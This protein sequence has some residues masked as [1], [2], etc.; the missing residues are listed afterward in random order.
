ML[1]DDKAR[2]TFAKL[3]LEFSPVALKYTYAPPRDI[4][5]YEGTGAFCQLVNAASKADEPFYIDKDND[6]C[7]GKVA[8][9]MV[10]DD[11]FGASGVVGP[12]IDMYATEAPNSRLHDLAPILTPGAHNCVIMAPIAKCTFDPDILMIVAPT[13]KAEIILRA[14]SWVSGDPWESK[15]TPVSSCIWMYAYPY[16][17][18]KVN[19]CI[20]G[21][22]HGLRRRNLYPAGMHL[23]S[24]PFPKLPETI[25]ALEN[26]K[27][28]ALYFRQDTEE[29][30]AELAAAQARWAAGGVSLGD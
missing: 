15:S 24:I 8:L 18:G 19:F 21:M 16:V 20:T 5:R 14:T 26:M 29:G 4:T 11:G 23:I 27:W 17:S 12:D 25:Y 10:P 6:E 13:D 7:F 2:E 3:E 1:I 9:G 30:R 28:K 22:H